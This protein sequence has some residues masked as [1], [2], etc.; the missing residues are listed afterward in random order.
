MLSERITKLFTLLQCS[1]TDIA[2]YA[3]CSPS[4]VSRLKSGWREP[5]QNSRTVLR[6]A[7][8]VY[9]YADYE[10][11]LPLLQ[12]LTGAAGSRPEEL[13]PALIAWMYGSAELRLPRSV[14]PRSRWTQE[15]RRQSFGDRL[16][17]AMTLLEMTNAQ[18]A[19]TLNVDVSLISRWRSVSDTHTR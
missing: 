6:L 15:L 8:G 13:V 3:G 5:K 9:A 18:L 19:A 16:D 1:N 2:R 11:L 12:E 4:N 10:N 17:R 7:R 14:T